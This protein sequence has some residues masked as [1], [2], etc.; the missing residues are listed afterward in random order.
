MKLLVY[1]RIFPTRNSSMTNQNLGYM[2]DNDRYIVHIRIEHIQPDEMAV[3]MIRIIMD[4]YH[5][6]TI[7]ICNQTFGYMFDNN[8]Q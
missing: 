2:M 4:Y 3:E 1:I 7:M 5:L 8:A 6:K